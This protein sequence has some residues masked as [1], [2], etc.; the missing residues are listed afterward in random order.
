MRTVY[1]GGQVFRNGRLET[2]DFSVLNGM[3][4]RVGDVSDLKDDRIVSLSGYMVFPGFADVHVHFREPGFSYKETIFTGSRAAAKGGYTLVGTMPNLNPAPDTK[5]HVNEQLKIIGRDAGIQVVPYGTITMERKGKTLSDMAGMK[6]LVIGFSDD[7]SGVDD[8]EM[9]RSAMLTA[10]ALDK[11]IAAHCEVMALVNGGVCHA[12]EF[13][14]SNSLPG[15]SSESEWKMIERDL[16][17]AK[18]T[19]AK[20]HVCH[21]S[22]KESVNLIRKAKA[23]G[24]NVTCETGPHYLI[25][26]DSMLKNEGR[27]K[28][29]P[30]I[31][32]EEDRKALVEGFIDGTID[33]L[34]TDHAPHS[35][36]E[37]SKGFMG[38]AMGVTGIE[39]AFS[40]MMTHLVEKGIVPLERLIDSLTKAPK[41][42]FGFSGFKIREG[43]SADFTV[44]D[45]SKKGVVRG[46][47]LVSMGHATPFEGF[48]KHG[49]IV[50]TVYQGNTVYPY[51][52]EE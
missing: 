15:I 1:T 41:T 33:I 5:E 45:P 39:T 38:S 48:E 21:I 51:N 13:A 50:L 9:M 12:G 11:V 34:A 2:V 30:P 35:E 25:M 28:M 49:D 37:K 26:N 10:K 36:E 22:T 47:E 16:R 23:E 6:E 32:S 44:F 3:F 24:V 27:Y 4:E 42:R 29:N 14:K 52:V 46:S 7:G 31:R 18:E 43:E 20:Y 19:G 8:E 17:L 40:M